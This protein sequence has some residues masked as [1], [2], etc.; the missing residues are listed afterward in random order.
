MVVN[1]LNLMVSPPHRSKLSDAKLF[2]KILSC[3]LAESLG[4]PM[5]TERVFRL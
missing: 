4:S 1:R 3:R 2:R 5:A